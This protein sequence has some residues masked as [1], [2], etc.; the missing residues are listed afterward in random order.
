[1]K[2]A[3]NSYEIRGKVLGIVGYGN[4]G[5]QL[6]VIAEGLGMRVRFFD[7]VK[8]LPLGNAQQVDTLPDAARRRRRGQPARARDPGHAPHDRRPELA[9]MRPGSMLINASR[10]TVVDIDALAAAL[11]SGH[12]HGA[13]IDVFPVEPRSNDDEFVLAP[14]RYRQRLP[15]AARRRQH[16]GGAG[17]Y[18]SEV[19][20]KLVRYSDNGTTTS[21]VNLPEVALPAHDGCHRLLHIH[22]NVPGVMGEINRVFSDLNVNI[23]A[24]YLQTN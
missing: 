13:G 11:D 24:Q 18:R 15:D 22:R 21:S 5:M 14:A 1:M 9:Q 23:A 4:I 16:D 2:S 12:L 19:A 20:E 17:Q 8:K 10:G 3:A 6:G 7:V